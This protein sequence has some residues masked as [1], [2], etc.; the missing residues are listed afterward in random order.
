MHELAI[1]DS[2]VA[3]VCERIEDARVTRVVLLIG[4]L[5]GVVPDA[6]RFCFDVCAKGTQ[7][8]GASL[9]IVEIPARGRCRDCGSHFDL[10]DILTLCH[11]GSSNFEMLS[12]AEL[13]VQEVEVL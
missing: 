9:E 4:S 11:C 5:S 10:Q 8:E 1:T 7:L 2:L 3:G 6:V 13:K 12:G